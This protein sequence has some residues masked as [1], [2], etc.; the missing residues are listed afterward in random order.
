MNYQILQSKLIRPE[1]SA[2]TITRKEIVKKLLDNSRSDVILVSSFAGSGKTTII[3]DWIGHCNCEHIWYS[4]DHWDNDLQLF[5]AYMIE[6]I[7]KLD[8]AAGDVLLQLLESIQSVGYTSFVRS[9]IT[10]LHQL[11]RE[12]VLVLDDYHVI[13]NDQIDAFLNMLIEHMPP[14]MKLVI[15][16]REDPAFPLSKHRLSK[17]LLEIRIS[18]LRF[19]N[20]EVEAFLYKQLQRDIDEEHVALFTKRTE[21][22]VAGI[23]L[24]SLSMQGLEDINSFI[25]KLSGSHKYIMDYLIEEALEKQS[26]EVQKFLQLTS[27]LDYFSCDLCDS[28][29]DAGH[30][31]SMRTIEYLMHRNMFI[32]PMDQERKW[33]RYHHLFRDLLSQRLPGYIQEMG[34]LTV[35]ELH[36]RAG[37]WFDSVSM[38]AEAIHHYLSG[39]FYDEAAKIIECRWAEM[40]LQLQASTW[41]AIAKQ[42]PASIIE[43]RPVLAMGYGWALIDTGDIQGGKEW[44]EAAERLYALHQDNPNEYPVA[45]LKQYE[46]LPATI[47]SAHAYVSAATEDIEGIFIHAKDALRNTPQDQPMKRAVIA[48]LLGVAHWSSGDLMEAEKITVDTLHSF[49]KDINDFTSNSFYMVLGELGIQMG[50]LKEAKSIFEKTIARID[51]TGRVQPVL[52][53][54][55]LGLAN[56]AYLEGNNQGVY[57]LLKKSKEYGQIYALIDWKYKYYLL[58]AKLYL[59]QGLFDAAL[60]SLAES[61][62]EYI[63]NPLPD[64]LSLEDMESYILFRSGHGMTETDLYKGFDSFDPDRIPYLREFAATFHVEQ[65]LNQKADHDVLLRA[66]SICSDLIASAKKQ[67]RNGDCIKYLILASKVQEALGQN[68]MRQSLYDEAVALSKAENYQ[69]PFI[70]YFPQDDTELKLVREAILPLRKETANQKLIEPLTIRELEVLGLIVEGLSNQ[71]IS[72]RLFLALSTVKG[73]NQTIYE[74]LEVRRRTEAV[75][76]ARVLGLV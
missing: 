2:L 75:A 55:Y 8:K 49:S 39:M 76:K 12:F 22:W 35:G 56:I 18:D 54:L 25:E 19:T 34:G 44:L 73:Y 31:S 67:K 36:R 58:F 3:S 71:E 69:R 41:L 45:D 1:V 11:E 38:S 24:A 63:M 16:T 66:A 7:I 65:A 72:N 14:R 51:S 37:K 70:D 20:E 27:L 60:E 57:D 68:T 4:L 52:A 48:M 29:L 28:L 50:R 32:I 17:K 6:G 42:L 30:G 64:Y 61:K 59:S 5:F 15:I 53:S 74:K 21:G 43:K 9:I 10:N 23:Q 33:Y 46:L 62:S 26:E 47:A 13:E 40:D